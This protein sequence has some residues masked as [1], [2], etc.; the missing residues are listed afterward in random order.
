MSYLRHIGLVT[1][2]V[3]LFVGAAGAADIY[4]QVKVSYENEDQLKD[5]YRMGLDIIY[6]ESD[7]LEIVTNPEKLNEIVLRGFE[8]E[9][10][11]EDLEKFYKSRLDSSKDMGGYKTL[12]EVNAYVDGIIADHPDIC[13]DK[14]SI[15][16]TIEGRD[17]WAI[18]ISDN[19]DV[20]EDEP[21][22][23]YTAAIHAREVI[24]PEVVLR[25]M[26]YLTDNYATD[27]EAQFLVDNREIWFMPMV[28][29]DGYYYNER[30]APGGGGM[31]RKNCRA[32][33]ADTFGVDLNRNW[34]H[35]WGYDDN[36]SSPDTE[37]QTYRGTEAFSEPETQNLRD[38]HIAH[39]FIISAY[40]HSSSNCL[41]WPWSYNQS[42]TNDNDIF[43]SMADSISQINGYTAELGLLGVA[44]GCTNDWVYGEQTLKNKTYG[45]TVEVGDRDI[46][47]F[48][49][50][51][52]R[53]DTLCQDNME[54]LRFL[55]KMAGCMDSLYR[56]RPAMIPV[57]NVPGF[58]DVPEY[59]ATWAYYDDGYNFADLFELSEL[60]NPDSYADECDDFSNWNNNGFQTSTERAYSGASS[61]YTGSDIGTQKGFGMAKLR[62]VED[63]DSLK[64]MVYYDLRYGIDY[65]HVVV[66]TPEG[67]N[68]QDNNLTTLDIQN[69][70]SWGPGLTGSSGGWVECGFNLSSLAGEYVY[71]DIVYNSNFGMGAPGE[72]VYF[73][74]IS[75]IDIFNTEVIITKTGDE[76]S[77]TFTDKENG[78]Y[79]YRMRA[80]DIDDQYGNY[81]PVYNTIV[82]IPPY[83]C[84]DA[85]AD[86]IV[87]VSDAVY[88][89]NYVFTPGSPA[90]DPYEA[91]E[92][93]CDET[94]DISDAVY[95]VNF[96]FVP[97]SPPP[98]ACK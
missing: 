9:I 59:E 23:F 22:V 61:F 97:G 1:L 67:Y 89:V 20:D 94:V 29:P 5:L 35:M 42:P 26:D 21:E 46:D 95:L 31:W 79:W 28:N 91:G 88:L 2:L 82:E 47:G 86:E 85:N 57:L 16:Q 10:I 24:T 30:H 15:G 49:P 66:W 70:L 40:F 8:T 52:D 38:F 71:F 98:G 53:I 93:N 27:P 84:G 62:P 58:V 83:I 3:V 13:S 6:A 19:P 69:G 92:V 43:Y 65:I 17:M 90:P 45:F 44:N 39:D 73:D 78:S 12:S 55:T 50:M 51:V 11:Q 75:P 14:I 77:H 96:V 33:G 34:G 63:G 80:M 56:L 81:G 76:Y 68:F 37:D 48:W 72:G 32:E 18:K 64:F 74:L 60:T 25:F 36:G 87:D 54:P 4:M 41:L 7:F